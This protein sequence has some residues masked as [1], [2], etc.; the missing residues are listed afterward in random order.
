MRVT[1]A[2]G[3]TEVV[4][5]MRLPLVSA[6][7]AM[8]QSGSRAG[9]TFRARL[10]KGSAKALD[11]LL[12]N[13]TVPEGL[14]GEEVQ[15]WWAR[16]QGEG[17]FGGL[18]PGSTSRKLRVR[19]WSTE[20]RGAEEVGRDRIAAALGFA[21]EAR[22]VR[23]RVSGHP[24]A[25]QRTAQAEVHRLV[26]P[27]VRV[28]G[29]PVH[30]SYSPQHAPVFDVCLAGLPEGWIG[31]VLETPKDS[32]LPVRR[33]TPVCSAPRAATKYQEVGRGRALPAVAP[34]PPAPLQDEGGFPP[35]EEEMG[36]GSGDESDIM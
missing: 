2:E 8:Q 27:T 28:V 25:F 7:Q 34:A 21:V 32:R 23:V 31:G 10:G 11:C 29:L 6:R 3:C 20:R 16:L 14:H 13:I 15:K 35:E 5:Q 24:T 33:W 1:Q 30:L 12:E 22:T 26:G 18:A 19:V 36:G 17:W 9:I 4:V